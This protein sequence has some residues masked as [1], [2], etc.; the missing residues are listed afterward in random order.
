MS[1]DLGNRAV[2][3]AAWLGGGQFLRQILAIGTQ[4]VLARLLFPDDFGL[5]AMAFAASEIA[6]IL[7]DFGLGSAIIQKRTSNA[8]ILATC[9]WMNLCIGILVAIGLLAASPLLTSYFKQPEIA[10]LLLPLAFNMVVSASMVVPQAL[11]TQRLQFREQTIAQII[12]S[13][14]GSICAISVAVS[15]GGVWALAVQPVAGTLV[16]GVAY[17]WF[18]RWLPNRRPRLSS[19][20]SMLTFSTQLLGVSLINTLGRNIHAFIL[21]RLLSSTALGLYN[22]ASGITGTI[23]F[24]VSSVIVRVM[25]P[26]LSKLQDDPERAGTAWIKASSAIA[27]I[28]FPAM[29]GIIAIAPDLVPVVFGEQWI[30]AIDVLRILCLLMAVQSVLTTS[31]TVL[32]AVARTDL[33]LRNSLY[34]TPSIAVALLLGVEYGIEGAAVGYSIVNIIAFVVLSIMAC[35]ELRMPIIRYYHSLLPWAFA[36]IVMG[37]GVTLSALALEHQSPL[38]RLTSCIVIGMTLYPGILLI[39]ARRSTLGLVNDIRS[40][41]GLGAQT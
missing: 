36:A 35:R 27:I 19:I 10:L 33:L 17:F 16:T 25:F 26:T 30:P 2:R 11:L 24:Q 41:M 23:I 34:L 31:S 1:D 39:T 32:M 20:K 13:V 6:Q 3:G 29:A 4:V 12:G 37:A 15:G 7:T 5:F 22:F 9:F 8:I 14:A 18:A 28:S 38:T 40:R 21:G